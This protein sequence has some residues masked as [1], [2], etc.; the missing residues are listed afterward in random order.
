MTSTV[1]KSTIPS[2]H[3]EFSTP[4]HH[5]TSEG[6]S[7]AL[8]VITPSSLAPPHN[9]YAEVSILKSVLPHPNIIP[10]LETFNTPAT[11]GSLSHLVLVF[12]FYTTSL[13]DLPAVPHTSADTILK[14]FRDTFSALA[15]LHQNGII[16]R[17]VKPSNILFNYT[18]GTTAGPAYLADF[19]IAWSAIT[20][21]DGDEPPNDKI[22]DVGTTHYRPLE[23]L[24]G[25]KGYGPE[26][27][28]WAMGCTI[29]EYF[30]A[31]VGGENVTFFDAGD[32]GSELRL[33]ASIF[34]KLGTP[35]ARSWPVC[36]FSL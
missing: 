3:A 13:A 12:P 26:L 32:L 29:A 21:G 11:G 10:L 16:H 5:P 7:V 14:I 8:K 9:C 25:Y 35:N 15:H 24:F 23:I 22:T 27:D 36:I 19:G 33:I 31:Q 1:Y 2:H 6:L 4:S 28:L 30:T 18:D 17:D 34:Q 20:H